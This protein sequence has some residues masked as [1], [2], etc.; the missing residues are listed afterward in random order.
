MN[1]RAYPFETDGA[2]WRTRHALALL[3][4]CASLPMRVF[5]VALALGFG[6]LG[7]LALATI[8]KPERASVALFLAGMGVAAL[9]GV[10][11]TRLLLLHAEARQSRTPG[12]E[13]AIGGTVALV[14]L[15]TVLL[16]ALVLAAGGVALSVAVCAMA[17]AAGTGVL[18]ATLPRIFYI[19]LCLAP[20]TLGVLHGLAERVL[21]PGAL[22]LPSMRVDH[23]ILLTLPVVALAVWRW[24]KV[25]RQLPGDVRSVW[26]QPALTTNP[27]TGGSVGWLSGDAVSAQLPDWM[28]PAGQTAGAGP[29]RPVRSIRAL[30]GTPFAPLSGGQLLVQLGIGVVVIAYFALQMDGDPRDAGTLV[31]GAIGGASVMVVMYAQRLEAIYSKRG[32]ELDELALLPGLGDVPVRR[33]RLLAAMAHSPV[34]AMAL[35]LALLLGMGLAV[36]LAPRLLGLVMMAGFGVVL[37]TA[38]SCLRPLAGLSMNAW[39]MLLM[40]APVLV[41][42]IGTIT[43]ATAVETPGPDAPRVLALIWLASYAVLGLGIALVWRRLNRR[44]H[45]FLPY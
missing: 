11:L 33:E 39:R 20:V 40:A 22:A 41:L 24:L 27:R 23:V 36:E 12:V 44:A 28:W 25:S 32:S 45:P 18:A 9:W 42:A 26:W 10:W 8:D 38:L 7:W 15:A 17:L 13:M 2:G 5:A 30:M 1:A 6:A 31:G 3:S 37:V 29:D 14:F 43:Y 16:P 4:C 19:A 21:P 35:V 34:I